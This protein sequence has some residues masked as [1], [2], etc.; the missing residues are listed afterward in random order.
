MV[1]LFTTDLEAAALA[2]LDI[3]I[4][5]SEIRIYSAKAGTP[6]QLVSADGKVVYSRSARDTY[7]VAVPTATLPSGVYVLRVADRS[8]KV[9]I[10]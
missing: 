4:S 3:R 6:V 5:G 9:F 7:Y 1:R 8:V 10:P 2:G